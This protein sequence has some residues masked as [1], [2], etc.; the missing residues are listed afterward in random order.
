MKLLVALKFSDERNPMV[1]TCINFACHTKASINFLHVVDR[2]PLK[3]SFVREM[4]ESMKDYLLKRGEEILRAAKMRAKACGVA[5]KTTL[6]EGVPWEVILKEAEKHDLLVMRS[7][8]FS[9]EEKLGSVAEN[10]LSRVAKPVM[11]VN[12][13]Q[14]RFD[15]CLVPVDGS[16]ESFKALYHIKNWS[17]TY[18]FKKVLILLIHKSSREEVVRE[19]ISKGSRREI[20]SGV[21]EQD[22]YEHRVILEAAEGIVEGAAEKVVSEVVHI[23]RGDIA[24][25]IL[26]YS[27]ERGAD[28]IFIGMMGKGRISR[29]FM[30]SV[31][32]K[33]AS[34]SR[35]PVVI[36]PKQY[37]PG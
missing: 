20:L 14:R 33:V 21:S 15:V 28:M 24:G 37:V 35:V 23:S 10:V 3:R 36:F 32:R 8:V 4:P 25:A 12:Q 30:G 7:R 16:D 19:K 29:F 26:D 27:G 11:L 22:M 13:T 31:S 18:N 9:P 1:E 34:F 2:T 5:V 17:K 6:V